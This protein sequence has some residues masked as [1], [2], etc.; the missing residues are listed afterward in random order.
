[1][2]PLFQQLG[3]LY[4]HLPSMFLHSGQ[5]GSLPGIDLVSA[6]RSPPRTFR[7]D[8]AKRIAKIDRR[9]FDA[10]IILITWLI[11][12]ERNGRVFEGVATSSSLLCAA[13]EDEWESWKAAGLLTAL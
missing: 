13:I 2:P 5:C 6:V 11:W 12:K 9:T 7:G 3:I 10:G 4:A 1:M 8:G